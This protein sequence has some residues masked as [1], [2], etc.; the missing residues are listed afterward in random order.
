M[1]REDVIRGI[2]SREMANRSIDAERVKKA[3]PELY[4]AANEL[5]GTWE[6]ALEY[7]GTRQLQ[8]Q[9]VPE[10]DPETVL[11][12]LRY[13][14]NNG[15]ALGARRNQKR[16][17]RLFSA[18]RRHF[19]TW[20]KALIAAGINVQRL[21]K[22]SRGRDPATVLL[23]INERHETGSSMNRCDVMMDDNDLAMVAIRLFG[24]WGRAL[25]AAGLTPPKP[26]S[27]WTRERILDAIQHNA[28]R[29]HF[30]EELR[31]PQNATQPS[32]CGDKAVWELAVGIGGGRTHGSAFGEHATFIL[33]PCV[34]RR[35]HRFNIFSALTRFETPLDSRLTKH[36]VNDL[37]EEFDLKSSLLCLA[38]VPKRHEQ[39]G[40]HTHLGMTS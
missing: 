3:D 14:C 28:S 40:Q 30:V 36:R 9:A 34:E 5:F 18:T 1:K 38:T 16:D 21:S 2:V 31:S 8:K 6:T 20:R 10:L 22:G 37:A 23:K 39:N 17:R 25:T 13:L 4:E 27:L 33:I 12:K 11:K 32:R 15:Y 7:A 19:G 29:R 24:S 35:R 26:P